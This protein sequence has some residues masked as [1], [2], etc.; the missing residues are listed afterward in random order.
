MSQQ[1]KGRKAKAGNGSGGLSR[2]HR[3]VWIARWT[4]ANGRRRKRS[5][6]TTDKAA[7]QRI[8]SKWLADEALRRSGVV[9]TR[10]EA[11][12]RQSRRPIAEHVR[13]W[14]ASM[15]CAERHRE[16]LR[17]RV[18]RIIDGC[19]LR[20]WQDVSA[21]AVMAYL[22]DLRPPPADAPA[23]GRD[24]NAGISA[25]TFNFYLAAMK[26][27]AQWM[28]RDQRAATNPL[29][30]LQRLNI[31]TDRRHDRAALD[32]DQ[33]RALIRAAETGPDRRGIPGPARA[34]LYRVSL[35]TGIRFSELASLTAGDFDPDPE[36]PALIV[37]AAYSKRRR[38]DR[39]P[40]RPALAER[41]GEHLAR[42]APGAPAFDCPKPDGAA[43][44]IRADLAAA[45]IPYRDDAGRVR[46]WH[47]L[48][49]SFISALAAGGVAPKTAQALA[50]HSTITLTLD[51]YTHSFSGDDAAA[52]AALPDLDRTGPPLAAAATGTDDSAAAPIRG[53]NGGTNGGTNAGAS[54]CI[55]MHRNGADDALSPNPGDGVSCGKN[56][57]FLHPDASPCTAAKPTDPEGLEPPT[58]GSEDRRSIQLS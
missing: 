22:N 44:I 51:R 14:A 53:T 47:C 20:T 50:R 45:G 57:G 25:Q 15:Q 55:A 17:G 3:G 36:A 27:F 30:H 9:D 56:R 21:S 8:L 13:D 28:L 23:I 6:Q 32:P 2:D 49:H 39:L 29:E 38:E 43:R 26:Q 16:L 34:L 5:T 41:I 11:L 19:G 33:Q 7:A 24:G 54:R 4:A 58:Y 1:S 10:A 46:D 48:R 42:K 12:A 40:L 18:E 35:E 52:L 31:R 37:R